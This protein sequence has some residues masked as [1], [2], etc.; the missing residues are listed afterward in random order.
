MSEITQ[1]GGVDLQQLGA[2]QGI[3]WIVDVG[4]RGKDDVRS[5]LDLQVAPICRD[6]QLRC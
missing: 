1:Y 5:S 3:V 4:L 6:C 2:Y